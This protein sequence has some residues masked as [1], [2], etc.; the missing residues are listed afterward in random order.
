MLQ[1]NTQTDWQADGRTDRWTDKHPKPKQKITENNTHTFHERFNIQMCRK[2]ASGGKGKP[3][4]AP[5]EKLLLLVLW[6]LMIRV[7]LKIVCAVACILRA[8]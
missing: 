8:K 6:L 3:A 4:A 5:L 2:K 7:L 1:K